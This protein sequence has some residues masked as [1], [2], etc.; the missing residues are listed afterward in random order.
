MGRD[1]SLKFILQALLIT[2]AFA[3]SSQAAEGTDHCMTDAA[4][5]AGGSN[6]QSLVHWDPVLKRRW[7]VVEDCGLTDGNKKLL[8]LEGQA[9][10]PNS[11][12]T[13]FPVVHRGDVVRIT[14]QDAV[15][16]MDLTGI[17]EES[18]ALGGRVRVHV[19]YPTKANVDSQSAWGVRPTTLLTTVLGP[20]QVEMKQ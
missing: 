10:L 8:L 17:A 1:F 19:L 3:A 20:H 2:V 5:E 13:P 6:A 16:R 4:K 9:V 14:K 18:G 15:T 11:V 7:A 12:A